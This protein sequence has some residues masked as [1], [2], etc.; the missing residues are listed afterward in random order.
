VC[1]QVAARLTAILGPLEK[2]LTRIPDRRKATCMAIDQSMTQI[3]V[4]GWCVLEG[5]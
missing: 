4:S 3:G 1:S 2:R 5:Y